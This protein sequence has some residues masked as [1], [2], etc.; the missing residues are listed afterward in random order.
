MILD[1]EAV[2]KSPEENNQDNFPPLIKRFQSLILDQVFLIICMVLFSQVL[3]NTDE[4][5]TGV[6][7]GMLLAGLVIV[8]EPFCMTFGCTIGNYVSGIRVRKFIDPE[9]R[10]S[11]FQSYIRFITKVCLGFYFLFYCY[12]Q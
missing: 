3:S 6:L 12:F 5:N 8:Y 4:E 9:K 1:S 10:I 7:R 11:I 2:G